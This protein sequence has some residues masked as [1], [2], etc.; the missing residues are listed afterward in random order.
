MHTATTELLFQFDRLITVMVA[1]TD[2]DHQFKYFANYKKPILSLKQITLHM[3][4]KYFSFS[5][6]SKTHLNVHSQFSGTNNSVYRICNAVRI[7]VL[8]GNQ[9]EL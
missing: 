3:Q 2:N 4:L 5:H 1:I 8:I 9:A 7:I 6:E